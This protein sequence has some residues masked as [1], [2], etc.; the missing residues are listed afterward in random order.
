[1]IKHIAMVN[2]ERCKNDMKSAECE[3]V[4]EFIKFILDEY[5]DET[6]Q[7]KFYGIGMFDACDCDGCGITG[8]YETVSGGWGED[9][10]NLCDD[11]VLI[12]RY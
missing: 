2:Y 4:E 1:M 6:E 10:E 9:N 7:A 5:G 12:D 8:T 3:T 11:C